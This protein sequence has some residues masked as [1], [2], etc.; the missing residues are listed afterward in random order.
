MFAKTFIEVGIFGIEP[1]SRICLYEYVL[2]TNLLKKI[3]KSDTF[4]R[5]KLLVKLF[6]IFFTSLNTR[7]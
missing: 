6:I 4:Y 5:S 1:S 3:E 2:D 7:I